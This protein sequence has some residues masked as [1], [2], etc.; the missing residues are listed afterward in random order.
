MLD[1]DAT[2][3]LLALSRSPWRT[4]VQADNPFDAPADIQGLIDQGLIEVQPMWLDRDH[5]M[6]LVWGYVITDKGRIVAR[7]LS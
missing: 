3:T 4:R 7:M 1:D 6:V 5:D 2:E